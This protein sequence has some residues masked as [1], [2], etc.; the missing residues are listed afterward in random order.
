MKQAFYNIIRN[1]VQAM[2]NGG[3]LAIYGYSTAEYLG[4]EFAD[5]GG[6]MTPEA[7]RDMFIPFKTTK[8]SGNGI[9]TM[10]IERVCR[11][12]GAEFGVV[13]EAERGTVFQ[14]RFPTGARRVRLLNHEG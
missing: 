10:I 1:A 2:S 6:G 3:T 13:T 9:G 4:I 12:H 14:I 11:E 7:L 5:T 8:A